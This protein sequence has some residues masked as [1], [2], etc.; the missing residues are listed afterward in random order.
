MSY[1]KEFVTALEFVW[2]EGFLSP[3]GPEEI[4]ALIG[5]HDLTGKRILDFGSGLGGV[6][7][8]LA[9]RYGVREVVGIDI[10]PEVIDLA[11]TLIARRG[12]SDR[13]RFQLTA[14]GPLPFPDQAFDVVFSKDAMVHVADKAALYE[15]IKRVLKPGGWLIASDWLWAP[16]A[17][18]DPLVKAWNGDNE[19]GFAFT[20]VAEARAALIGAGYLDVETR[21]RSREISA[22]N[23]AEIARLESPA[24]G[25]PCREGWRGVRTWP[26]QK[27]KGKATRS[28]CGGPRPVPSLG[29]KTQQLTPARVAR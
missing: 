17:S 15:E 8:L 11:R 6:D 19:M 18:T 16:D 23:R 20:T 3:G 24:L 14:P 25:V 4:E 26:P 21:E 2:G 28:R 7:V 5:R 1:T 27:R 10:A 29:A 13:V 9:E 12:L 22:Y